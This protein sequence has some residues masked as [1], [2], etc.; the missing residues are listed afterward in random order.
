[1]RLHFGDVGVGDYS[2]C[3]GRNLFE[4]VEGGGWR[5]G[6]ERMLVY[7]VEADGEAVV[8]EAGGFC[9]AS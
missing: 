9:Y 7:V 1:M 8:G 5:G 2:A 3:R 6:W 4:F